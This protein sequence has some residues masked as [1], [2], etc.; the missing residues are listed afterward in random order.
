MKET[1][2]CKYMK[3]I[4]FDQRALDLSNWNMGRFPSYREMHV[5][6]IRLQSKFPLSPKSLSFI[7]E[8]CI[9]T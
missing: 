8:S 4:A 9:I 6:N 7:V 1:K 2:A 5:D 3:L